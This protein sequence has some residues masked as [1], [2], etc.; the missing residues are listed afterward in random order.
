MRKSWRFIAL[1]S[2]VLLILVACGGGDG[3]RG[4]WDASQ[5]GGGA[6]ITFSSGGR[7]TASNWGRSLPSQGTYSVA[8]NNIEFIGSDGHVV[9]HSFERTENTITVGRIR[10]YRQ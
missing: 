3:L 6:N 9:V 4:T 5:E 2:A 1:L 10:L 7:F 8:G